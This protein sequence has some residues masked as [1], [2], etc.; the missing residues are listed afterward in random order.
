MWAKG[1]N[2]TWTFYA[3]KLR[4][5]LESLVIMPAKQCRK[6]GALN[7]QVVLNAKEPRNDLLRT[8]GNMTETMSLKS[9]TIFM[10]LSEHQVKMYTTPSKSSKKAPD[11]PLHPRTFT[12][13][14]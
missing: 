5:C 8:N 1:S 12:T 13:S 9:Q 3:V 10:E 11:G 2:L 6:H 7:G 14:R 4:L